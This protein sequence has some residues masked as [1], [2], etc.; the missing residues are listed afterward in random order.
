M[1]YLFLSLFVSLSVSPACSQV[2]FAPAG[3]EWYYRYNPGYF[4]NN[5]GGFSHSQYVADTLLEGRVC[6][7]IC[8]TNFI[9]P[10]SVVHCGTH[11]TIGY[12]Y[13]SGD[14]IFRYESYPTGHF[15]LLFRNNFQ[16]GDTF[17]T[18]YGS[19]WVVNEIM[20]LNLNNSIV[21][22]FRLDD[23]VGG[24]STYI[25]DL[26]GPETGI[27]DHLPG[28]IAD[29]PTLDLRC[30]TDANFPQV[31]L[32]TEA[33]DAIL[34]SP[35]P[36]FLVIIYPNPAHD[37][38]DLMFKGFL[39]EPPNIKVWDS[40]G[41][42]VLEERFDYGQQRLNVRNLPSGLYQLTAEVAGTVVEQKFV[43][44]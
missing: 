40:L 17:Q 5:S 13:Q 26:F 25:Y 38:M 8:S 7:Q 21:H 18:V 24:G 23:I 20:A 35:E 42:M 29:A 44:Y 33:C 16:L 1:K 37:F 19:H 2:E 30:Y 32:T 39:S 34:Q 43:K 6:K 36:N 41:R 12:I 14:S 28:E 31:N 22:R 4:T 27:F 3:A 11:S 9:Y 10:V 15:T